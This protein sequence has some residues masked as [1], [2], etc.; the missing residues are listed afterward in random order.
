[1]KAPTTAHALVLQRAAAEHGR[2]REVLLVRVPCTSHRLAALTDE[3]ATDRLQDVL[4]RLHL[5]RLALQEPV[6]ER[7]VRVRQSLE[8]LR[9]R[10]LRR[11]LHRGGQRLLLEGARLVAD[12]PNELP[13]SGNTSNNR[14]P[15]DVR[16][17]NE[18]VVLDERQLQPQTLRAESLLH[19]LQLR[20]KLP[21]CVDGVVEVRAHAVQLV[22]VEEAGQL[23]AVRLL[24][25]RLG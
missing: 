12:K 24:P 10:L 22:H 25:N 18:V 2:Q 7:L 19:H 4:W 8:Q 14:L 23:V 15:Y 9:V 3:D 13:V 6:A 1:M 21:R 20:F 17:A 5:R 16:H 11:L